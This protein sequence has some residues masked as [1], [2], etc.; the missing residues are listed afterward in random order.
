[1]EYRGDDFFVVWTV[2]YRCRQ[3]FMDEEETLR[4]RIVI[5]FCVGSVFLFE[6]ILKYIFLIFKY[7]F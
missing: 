6:N 3:I 2:E 7:Y 4:A 5:A 1:V